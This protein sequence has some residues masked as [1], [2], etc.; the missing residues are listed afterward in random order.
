MRKAKV[1]KDGLGAY[2]CAG[3]VRSRA[4]P[5]PLLVLCP[6]PYLV[7]VV[8]PTLAGLALPPEL[9]LPRSDSGF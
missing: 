6:S 4:P 8:I 5:P 1:A 9:S 3:V 2:R 7:L